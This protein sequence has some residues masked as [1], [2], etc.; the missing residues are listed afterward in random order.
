MQVRQQLGVRNPAT[1][2][3]VCALLGGTILLSVVGYRHL[4]AHNYQDFPQFYMGGIMARDGDWD[5]LYPVPLPGSERN[6]GEF[7]TSTMRPRYAQLATE[8]GVPDAQRFIQAPPI[9]LV[10]WPLSFLSYPDA[11]L[12]WTV[13]SVAFGMMIAWQAGAVFERLAGRK[14][15]MQGLVVLLVATSPNM[16]QS[17]RMGQVSTIVGACLGAAVLGFAAPGQS[18]ARTGFALFFATLVK[19]IGV[20]LLPVPLAMRQFG[21]VA[22]TLGL[23]IGSAVISAFIVGIDP[24]REWLM[25]IAPTLVRSHAWSANQSVYGVAVRIH[26]SNPLPPSIAMPLRI[27]SLASLATVLTLIFTRH[28]SAW[29]RPATIFAACTAL[30]AWAH[31]FSPIFWNHYYVYLFPLWGW[32]AWEGLQSRTAGILVALAFI[33]AWVP[34]GIVPSLAQQMPELV[35]DHMLLSALLVFAFAVIRLAQSKAQTSSIH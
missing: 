18:G 16:Y 13:L 23:G 17:C 30:L 20:I 3:L 31:V 29:T 15:H 34:A 21:T 19:Y 8:A 10:L 7:D 27:T 22:W 24:W 14:T 28:R 35:R 32:L 4:T 9:A 1:F 5:S 2:N 11:H 25:V 12:A 26:G 6:A 33:L